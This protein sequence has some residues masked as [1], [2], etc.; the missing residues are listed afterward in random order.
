MDLDT[1]FVNHVTFL[2]NQMFESNE[3]QDKNPFHEGRNP[4]H[5]S[6]NS[7]D[8][9]KLHSQK[10]HKNQ[11]TLSK[12]QTQHFSVSVEQIGKMGKD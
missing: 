2:R 5:S 11:H 6:I 10:A 7:E 1:Q 9:H 8:F 12:H 4:V 3:N